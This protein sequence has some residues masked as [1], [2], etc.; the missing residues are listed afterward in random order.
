MRDLDLIQLGSFYLVDVVFQNSRLNKQHMWD[1][2][3]RRL[4]APSTEYVA[5]MG[6][7]DWGSSLWTYKVR[8]E[9]ELSPGDLIVV[10]AQDTHRFKVGKVARVKM[11]ELIPEGVTCRWVVCKVDDDAY[12]QQQKADE[13]AE[14][15]LRE[16]RQARR[17]RNLKQDLM[18]HL[19]AKLL[20]EIRNVAVLTHGQE[21][22]DIEPPKDDP[23]ET[24]RIKCTRCQLFK[25]FGAIVTKPENDEPVCF[26]C[27]TQAER[28]AWDWQRK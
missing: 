1:E 19:G 15:T 20:E 11:A 28:M 22:R 10:P 13:L 25:S 3:S 24:P 4:I 6:N 17:V 26:W 7:P 2:R 21:M 16:V 8:N 12:W 23:N 18:D 5:G 27:S 9:L 14:V